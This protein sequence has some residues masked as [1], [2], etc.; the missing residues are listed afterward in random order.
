M[1]RGGLSLE[2]LKA[3]RKRQEDPD[4][5]SGYEPSIRAVRGEAPSSSYAVRL[6]ARKVPGREIHLLSTGETATALL[7]LYHPDVVGLQEQR[8]LMPDDRPHPL[9]NFPGAIAG[10]LPKLGGM[11]HVATQLGYLNTLPRLWVPNPDVPAER[12]AIIYPYIGDLLWAIRKSKNQFYC[13]NWSIK[14]DVSVF[15]RPVEQLAESRSQ[16]NSARVSELLERHELECAYYEGAGIR[17]VLLGA[18]EIDV[19]VVDN[20]R[21]LFLHHRNETGISPLEQTDML[22]RFRRCIE[23]ETPPSRLI[24]HLCG[25][26][27]YSPE[28]C[29]DVLFQGIWSRTLRVDL[30]RPILIDRPLRPEEKDVLAVYADWFREQSC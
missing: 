5:G 9:H 4:W 23:A 12:M 30:F 20:L 28:A 14:D 19:H 22:E 11:V 1:G 7:G 26:G 29:R 25:S 6:R 13:I 10:G 8:A 21:H 2:R 18:N 15:K 17:T 3:I 27:R 16:G 24:A